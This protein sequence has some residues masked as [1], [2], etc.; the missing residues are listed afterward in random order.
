M[1]R[2]YGVTS[3]TPDLLSGRNSDMV[4]IGSLRV[5]LDISH[6]ITTQIL[7]APLLPPTSGT[8]AGRLL[9]PRR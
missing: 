5:I 3:R 6:A 7:R 8:H 4:S 2:V 9:S 1:A